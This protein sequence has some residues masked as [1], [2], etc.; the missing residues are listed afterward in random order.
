MKY[1]IKIRTSEI[2]FD[3]S[4][5]GNDFN[6]YYQSVEDIEMDF[7]I[8]FSCGDGLYF[9]DLLQQDWECDN[10]EDK[11]VTEKLI[12]QYDGKVDFNLIR[13]KGKEYKNPY[14]SFEYDDRDSFMLER[15]RYSKHKVSV[16]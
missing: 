12:D 1:K 7:Q 15:L 6:N 10:L 2:T 3:T 14:L 4:L 16:R 13:Y 9:Q 8:E 11:I 5:D